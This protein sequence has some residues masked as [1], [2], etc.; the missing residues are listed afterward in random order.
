MLKLEIV[1]PERKVLS[2]LVDTVILPAS[3]GEICILPNHAPLISTLKSG[4]LSYSHGNFIG[5]LVVS[6]GFVEVNN[7]QV[8]VLADAAEHDYE[9]NLESAIAEKEEL[10]KALSKWTGSEEEFQE[11]REELDRVEARVICA[12]QRK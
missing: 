1:T 7:N 5:K 3:S 4:V 8:S 6:G 2:E 11:K 10:E 12:S 9:I